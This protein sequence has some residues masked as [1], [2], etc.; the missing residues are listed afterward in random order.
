MALNKIQEEMGTVEEE[1]GNEFLEAYDDVRGAMLDPKKV[2]AARMDEVKC[3]YG[4]KLYD[5]VPVS[6]CWA[7]IGKAPTGIKWLDTNKGEEKVPN[8]RSRCVAKEVAYFKQGS[9]FAATPPLEVM[10]MI[11]SSVATG[12]NGERLMIADV[13]RAYFHAKPKWLT[14]VKLPAEDILPG[15]EGMCGRLNYSMYGT[16]DAAMNWA[17]EYS[18]K[19]LAA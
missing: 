19:L 17:E 14:Y 2:Y 10:K 15:E 1:D 7:N 16:R 6:E 13:R 5:K 18:T 9:S 12:N 3:I 11:L 8:Y 4:M